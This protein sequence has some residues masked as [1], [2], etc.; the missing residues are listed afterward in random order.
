MIER[1][2]RLHGESAPPS[3]L[4]Q[5]RDGDARA[6]ADR[7]GHARPKPSDTGTRSIAGESPKS[8]LFVPLVVG[9]R[10]TGVISLQNVDREHA[11]GETDQRLL[12]TLAGSLSVALDNAR[13]VHETRQRV[14]ELATVNSVGQALVVAARARRADRARRRAGARDVRGR[15]RLRGAARRGGRTDRLRLLLRERRASARA[16]DRVRGG[17]HVADPR[18]ARAAPAQPRGALRR[19]GERRDA[20]S[21]LPRRADPRR[22]ARRSA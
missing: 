12:A 3:R 22:R 8:A 10:P 11:F 4:P 6:A 20:L 16:A 5:A 21:L 18:V 15:H 2:E 7:R 13:L 19:P 9:G 14:A 1:G 17:A